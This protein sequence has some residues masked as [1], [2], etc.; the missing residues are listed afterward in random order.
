M[1]RLKLKP[2]YLEEMILDLRNVIK[3]N[4]VDITVIDMQA[5]VV[6][7]SLKKFIEYCQENGF[8]PFPGQEETRE[9]I[10]REASLAMQDLH[11]MWAESDDKN[12]ISDAKEWYD[13]A[14]RCLIT[15]VLSPKSFRLLSLCMEYFGALS[16]RD[17]SKVRELMA[18]LRSY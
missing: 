14:T 4:T 9:S 7:F 8:Y 2:Q 17:T 3:E 13:N 10:F 11:P 16:E 6:F 5:E 1:E 18:E 12:P 15:Q